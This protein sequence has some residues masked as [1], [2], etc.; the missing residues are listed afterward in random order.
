MHG[1]HCKCHFWPRNAAKNARKRWKQDAVSRAF[2]DSQSFSAAKPHEVSTFV[3]NVSRGIWQLFTFS[4]FESASN[5][6]QSE[7]T[8]AKPYEVSTFVRNVSRVLEEKMHLALM[9]WHGRPRSFDWQT[10]AI[11]IKIKA[12]QKNISDPHATPA[13]GE[14]DRVG[15]AIPPPASVRRRLRN[16]IDYLEPACALFC[17]NL[18]DS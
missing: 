10:L 9:D 15:R 3:R 12:Q 7:K 1:G 2:L 8:A 17:W 14:G 4:L 18:I 5:P 11:A 13:A 16:G 6:L